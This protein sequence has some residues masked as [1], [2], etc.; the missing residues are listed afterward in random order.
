LYVVP[1]DTE[2][3]TIPPTLAGV[4][5]DNPRRINGFALGILEISTPVVVDEDDKLVNAIVPELVVSVLV[6][7]VG[8]VDP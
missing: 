4:S 7:P 6:E 5:F 2:S 1:G 3:A 8:P